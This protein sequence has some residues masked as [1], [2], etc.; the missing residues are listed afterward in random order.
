MPAI[1]IISLIPLNGCIF[2]LAKPS[3]T[4]LPLTFKQ[5]TDSLLPSNKAGPSSPFNSPEKVNG[6]KKHE[7]SIALGSLLLCR[8]SE[9]L[10][11]DHKTTQEVPWSVLYCFFI[12]I[13][14]NKWKK[15]SP[16]SKTGHHMGSF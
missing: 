10:I 4:A 15:T 6:H 9:S 11:K 3:L 5:P 2:L 13:F 16:K 1:P 7:Q 12:P 14:N 8:E